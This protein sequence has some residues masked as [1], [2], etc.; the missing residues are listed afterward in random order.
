LTYYNAT[1]QPRTNRESLEMLKEGGIDLPGLN[2]G[3]SM[4]E[5]MKRA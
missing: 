2:E 1:W 4:L 3:I 5:E